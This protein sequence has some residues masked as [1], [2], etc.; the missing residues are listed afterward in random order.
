MPP[1]LE[2]PNIEVSEESAAPAAAPEVELSPEALG[3]AA[4]AVAAAAEPAY[5]PNLKFK[6]TDDDGEKEA[7]FDEWVKPLV[8]KDLE[9]K[10]RDLFSKAKGVDYM[11]TSREKTRAEKAELDR[12]LNTVRATVSE[13]MGLREKD[14]GLFFEK[15]GLNEDKAVEYFIKKA[16]A[17][18]ALKDLPEPLRNLYNETETL[19]RQNLDMQRQ[20]EQAQS[21]SLA[22]TT[23]LL[24]T[25]VQGILAQPELAP[26]VT[27][28][29][30]RR[31]EPGAFINL[32]RDEGMLEHAM[33]GKLL[34]AA[35]AVQ[36]ALT[37]L[38][39]S[40][41]VPSQGATPNGA[42]AAPKVITQ[43]R[44]VVI[45]NVGSGTAAPV[46]KKPRSID[47]LRKLAKQKQHLSA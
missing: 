7:E 21:G 15:V 3:E 27:E 19:R 13:V 44:P 25:Q 43:P 8:N 4:A 23:Q 29:E 18:E 16:Q 36:R 12:Q 6:F 14:L 10:F 17:K 1:D 46:V 26:L 41:Q 9:D 11:K 35:D 30:K 37:R 38:A 39:M 24:T 42:A 20:I 47:D 33:T 28:Y 34:P 40:P 5:T 2:Q 22:S 32:V 31:G 45:P